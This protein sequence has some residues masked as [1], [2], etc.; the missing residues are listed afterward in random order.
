MIIEIDMI[1]MSNWVLT[2]QHL[3]RG[4]DTRLVDLTSPQPPKYFSLCYKTTAIASSCHNRFGPAHRTDNG[5]V[6]LKQPVCIHGHKSKNV[7]S[8][9]VWSGHGDD[10]IRVYGHVHAM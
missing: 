5:L 6:S 4:V 9:Q 10:R 3:D 7:F 8:R 1:A 2:L